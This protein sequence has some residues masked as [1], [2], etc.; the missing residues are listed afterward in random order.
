MDFLSVG[1]VIIIL[2]FAHPWVERYVQYIQ[3]IYQYISN[4]NQLVRCFQAQLTAII[5]SQSPERSLPYLGDEE[6]EA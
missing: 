4:S 5:L 3:L 2:L 6:A 1:P